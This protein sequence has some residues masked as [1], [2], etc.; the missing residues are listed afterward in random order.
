MNNFSEKWDGA[1][2]NI[3]IS[4][5]TFNMFR[6]AAIGGAFAGV[7]GLALNLIATSC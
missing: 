4:K 5:K 6:L 2:Q 3:T 1:S 7:L